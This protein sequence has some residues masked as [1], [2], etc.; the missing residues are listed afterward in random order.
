[1]PD[2]D[3]I[4]AT[5]AIR[6][7]EILSGGHVPIIAMTAHALKGD[8]ERCMAA[9]MDGYVTKPIRTVELFA[10]IDKILSR[11]TIAGEIQPIES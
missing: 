8:E 11:A 3:G 5:V 1:M 2:L 9:G 4:A 6:E 7:R 10:A